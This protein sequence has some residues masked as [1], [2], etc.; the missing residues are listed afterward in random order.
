MPLLERPAYSYGE[1]PAV[2]RFEDSRPLFLFD[3]CSPAARAAL[4]SGPAL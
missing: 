3:G 4:D 1:D 2:P